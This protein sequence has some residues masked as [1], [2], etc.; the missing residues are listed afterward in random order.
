MIGSPYRRH[1]PYKIRLVCDSGGC[2]LPDY[3]LKNLGALQSTEVTEASGLV[4]SR[5]HAGT[6]WTHNDN[7]DDTRL[8][9]IDHAGALQATVELPVTSLDWE[10]IAIGPGP[11][12]RDYLYVGDIGDKE[13]DRDEIVVHRIAEPSPSGT[14]QLPADQVATMTLAYPDGRSYNAETLMVDPDSG[15][16]YVVTKDHDGTTKVFVSRAP[17]GAGRRALEEIASLKLNK[18]HLKTGETNSARGRAITAG[19]IAADNS[20]LVLRS[21]REAFIWYRP[22]DAGWAEALADRPQRIDLTHEE[23]GEALA[24]LP[25]ASGFITVA[26]GTGSTIYRYRR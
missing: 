9:A 24:V 5:T 1:Y 19:D 7:E 16:L 26:E 20:V 3:A 21:Y 23:H 4:A 22:L 8:F 14:V 10:D 13:R 12:G 17:L 15:D 2:G 6:L 18:R 11:G 25:D